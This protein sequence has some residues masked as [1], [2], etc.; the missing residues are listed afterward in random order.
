MNKKILILLIIILLLILSS[1]LFYYTFE[2]VGKNLKNIGEI[3][4]IL[5]NNMVQMM[6]M[7]N[8]LIDI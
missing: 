1:L 2:Y 6:Y 5:V 7:N 8:L 3:Y 4:I